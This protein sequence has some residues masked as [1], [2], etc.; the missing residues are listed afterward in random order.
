MEPKKLTSQIEEKK[1]GVW[2][3]LLSGGLSAAIAR[4]ITNPIERL[5]I[6]RQVENAD[7]K[8]LSLPKSV[9]KFYQT[10]GIAG[11]FKGNFASILRIFP[12]SA[13]EFYSFEYFKNKIIRGHEKRQNSLFYTMICG[14]LAGIIAI[15]LTFPLDVARTRLA[16]NTA[17]SNLKENSL[18]STLSSLWKNEGI[19]GLYK[20]YSVTFIV[21]LNF[22]THLYFIRVPC[23]SL[24]LNK[25]LLIS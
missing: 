16:V 10:Q 11:I 15:T 19:R 25:Q 9:A 1:K 20:G 23:H 21:L 5:E 4:T 2:K 22:I 13:V 18:S 24:P 14:G 8:G 7:F 12:F 6:L 3:N 17:S